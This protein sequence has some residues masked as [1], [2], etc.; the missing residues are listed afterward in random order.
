M[1]DDKQ[2]PALTRVAVMVARY[3]GS[4][5]PEEM[6][7][8]MAKLE[9]AVRMTNNSNEAVAYAK[10]LARLLVRIT[11]DDG[12][13]A[14]G[15]PGPDTPADQDALV[16]AMRESFADLPGDRR[17]DVEK[18]LDMLGQD[19]KAVTLTFGPACDCAMGV[20]S[21][22]HNVAKSASFTDAVRTNIYACGDSCGRAMVV[23]PLA[24]ALYGTGGE[25]GIPAEWIE[26]TRL[27]G[28]VEELLRKVAG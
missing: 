17:A 26:R 15:G 5:S 16:A 2:M 11:S 20:P 25:R 19:T 7:R 21:A 22:L 14:L 3:A 27:A 4:G 8:L 24:G 6:D 23:G 1:P 12:V 9:N 18:A 13:D 10:G 28:E